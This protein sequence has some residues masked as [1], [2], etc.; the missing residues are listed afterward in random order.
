MARSKIE[1]LARPGTKPESWS[2]VTGCDPVSDECK[3]CWARAMA[4]RLTGQGKYKYR[5]GFEPT[6]HPDELDKPHRWQ[7][8]RTV[9][10]SLM[11]DL[12]HDYVSDAFIDDVFRVMA[13]TEHTYLL[14]TKR[15][16][17]MVE[18]SS[19][20][21]HGLD[22]WPP[23]IWAGVTIAHPDYLYRLDHLR[24]V[25]A[26]VRFVSFEPMLGTFKD[27]RDARPNFDRLDWV[28]VGAETG[29]GKRPM[30]ESAASM[31][32]HFAGHHGIPFFF[33]KNNDGSRLL[34]G[35]KYE[36]WPT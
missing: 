3:N 19:R 23:N 31:I 30:D 14:L 15:V 16:R 32:V 25:P 27:W 22:P 12:F 10:V 9:A 2:P 11:G 18:W 36:E 28:I 4:R 35:R 5:N 17:R 6:C 13:E 33:K 8:R 34:D 1:W 7:K 29:P 20:W 26:A 21:H 24:R